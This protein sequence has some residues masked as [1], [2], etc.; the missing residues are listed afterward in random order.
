M[1]KFLFDLFPL[2]LFFIAFRTFD[3]YTATAVAMAAAVAQIVWLKVRQH[4]IEGTHWINLG[5]IV[6]FGSATLFFQNDAFI[7][8][9]PTVLYWLFATVLIGSHLFLRRNLMQKLMGSQL[10]LPVPVWTKLNYSWALFFLF[11]G[12]VNLFVA[13]SG[14]FSE[15]QWVSFKVFGSLILLVIFIIVQ[16][17]W[18]G[19]YM[20][21]QSE[22]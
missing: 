14:Y 5:V 7:K 20:N 21:D 13:F 3:I 11:S 2:I 1:K 12:A 19:K 10:V 9:K 17:L 4:A 18:L 16:S 15:S 22:R 8:W 6:V